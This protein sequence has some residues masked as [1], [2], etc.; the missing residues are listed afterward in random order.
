VLAA[1]DTVM[2]YTDGLVET[3]GADV[4]LG[5]DRLMGE[6]ERFVATRSG[7]ADAVLNGVRA[8]DNDDRALILVHR[9]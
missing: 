9:D 8:G 6:A 1:G 2:L 3:P 5:I 7:G 4:E